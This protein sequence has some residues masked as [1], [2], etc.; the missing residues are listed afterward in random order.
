MGWIWP[1]PD[2][3]VNTCCGDGDEYEYCSGMDAG[4]DSATEEDGK[5]QYGLGAYD[6]VAGGGT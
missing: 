5:G 3:G 2:D 6:V 4:V 1:Y